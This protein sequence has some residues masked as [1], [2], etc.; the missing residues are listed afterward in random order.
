MVLRLDPDGILHVTY[1]P[2]VEETLADAEENFRA[3]AAW[4]E[5]PWSTLVDA[6]AMKPQSREVRQYNSR[7]EV[8]RRI[9]A[10]AVVVASPL[11][12]AIVNLIITLTRPSMPTRLFTDEAEAREWLKGFLE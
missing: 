3:M 8:V 9:R 12:R 6:R 2:G 10:S 5:G 4:G 7:P 11:S 1:L